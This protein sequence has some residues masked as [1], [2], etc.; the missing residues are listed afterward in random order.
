MALY[1]QTV[2]FGQPSRLQSQQIADYS[3]RYSKAW[4]LCVPNKMAH[5][6]FD[7]PD[8]K[9][10][11]FCKLVPFWQLQLYYGKIKGNTP[12]EQEDH[13]GSIPICT[14]EYVLQII[15]QLTASVNWSLSIT[16]VIWQRLTLLI[17]SRHG[18]S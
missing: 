11:V 14:R 3:S 4:T 1:V 15:R 17:F 12:K 8:S 6:L 10:D 9:A 16:A 18:V 13:S 5:N 2:V 7:Q